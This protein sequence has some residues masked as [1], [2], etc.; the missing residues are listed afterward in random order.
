MP[1]IAVQNW[2]QLML[3]SMSVISE[4]LLDV[5]LFPKEL[6]L[7]ENPALTKH[8]MHTERLK[9][10]RGEKNEDDLEVWKKFNISCIKGFQ[11]ADDFW[12]TLKY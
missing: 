3:D 9:P 10:A 5:H 6:I 12:W 2:V 7:F 1:G 11:G 8:K 4:G